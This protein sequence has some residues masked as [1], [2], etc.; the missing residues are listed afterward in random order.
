M[1]PCLKKI[2]EKPD[3]DED[4]RF[5]S[6]EVIDQLEE[7][8]GDPRKLKKPVRL[9]VSNENLI[10]ARINLAGTRLPQTTEILRLLR[11]NNI[12][13]RRYAIYMIGKFRLRD[14]LPEV[15]NS[16]AIPGLEL[17][18]MNILD[19]FGEEA[20]KELYRLY[21]NSSGNIRL[22]KL[23]IRLLSKSNSKENNDFLFA[24][25]WSNSRQVK[26]AAV[27][28]LIDLGFIASTEEKDK[29][30]QLISDI[31]GLVTWN[32]SAQ[33]CLNDHNDPALIEVL[34]KE[35]ASWM[36]FLFN[37]LSIAYDSGSVS[38]IKTNIEMRTAESV[39]YALEMVDMLIDK[40]VKAKL[41]ALID[42]VPDDK[43]LKNLHQFYPG[44]T[45]NYD[46]LPED[47][48]NR[49][50]NLISIWA[51]ACTLRN[52]NNINGRS[53]EE[54]VIALLFS[55]EK[56]LQE[57]TANLICRTNKE[58]FSTVS[59]R[60]PK[61]SLV[62][63]EKIIRGR[64]NKDEFL[65]EKAAFLSGIFKDISEDDLLYPAGA[66]IYVK[67]V[68]SVDLPVNQNY[69][70]WNISRNLSETRVFTLI[71]EKAAIFKESYLVSQDAFFYLLPLEVLEDFQSIYPEQSFEIYNYLNNAQVKTGEN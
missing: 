15:C 27:K 66:L 64:L 20:A 41:I 47:I 13:S 54:S 36:T 16:L 28:S 5:R 35:T 23:I 11:N 61:D 60:L 37:V 14:M 53:T 31:I 43:K 45:V 63:P 17:D 57:E 71:G 1:L 68:T 52:M 56:I 26:E 9:P 50:Y 25:L 67:D 48:I 55:P 10:N 7:T 29:L 59:S 12:E 58:I 69:I 40:S 38:W 34:K 18:A 49:D 30:H 4:L 44:E 2:A 24:R 62:I 33:C 65:M 39:S 22:S 19:S 3:V 8:K 51:K 70:L 32:I 6:A 42:P 21:L 46:Q